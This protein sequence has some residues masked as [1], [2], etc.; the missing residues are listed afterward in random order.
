MYD[1]N[2]TIIRVVDGDTVE[3]LIDLG[4]RT[5]HKGM[6]RLYAI[7]TPETRTRDLEEKEAGIRARDRLIELLDKCE[8]RVIL[9]S[10]GLDKYGRA[11]GTLIDPDGVDLNQQLILEG[12]AESYE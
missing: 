9:I 3:A 8:N 5:H 11:L 2:A 6:V 4:F 12:L 1:Y 10:H 7:D